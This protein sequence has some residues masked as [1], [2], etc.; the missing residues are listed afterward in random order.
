MRI[1]ALAALCQVPFE[2]AEP[3]IFRSEVS[4][5]DGFFGI[6]SLERLLEEPKL[7]TRAGLFKE[8]Q[9][10]GNPADY[11]REFVENERSTGA[12]F[13]LRGVQ[14]VPGP[15]RDMCMEIADTGWP[16]VHAVALESPEGVV[17]LAPHWDLNPVI[18]V[19]TVGR[20]R[21]LIYE[22]VV[23]SGQEVIDR[24]YDGYGSGF[25]PEQKA[26]MLPENAAFDVTLNPGDVLF[27]PA[28]WPHAPFAVGGHSLHM[29]V[30]ALPQQVVDRSGTVDHFFDL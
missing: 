13:T 18:A 25:T 22:P 6:D 11:T 9:L 26:A 19:Q 23:S 28:G 29:S 8:Q 14:R 17:S 2:K 16:A 10:I 24:W 12:A 30:C 21:W 20:K 5:P 3:V 4:D 27:V 15:V 1:H 7:V